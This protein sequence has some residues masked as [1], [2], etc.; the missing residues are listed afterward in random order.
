[1]VAAVCVDAELSVTVVPVVT[2]GDVAETVVP[3][4]SVTVLAET[5]V[6]SA[7]KER[8]IISTQVIS[9]NGNTLI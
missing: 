7:T 4:V 5:V 8:Y 9:E 3:V 1:M 2:V 6:S